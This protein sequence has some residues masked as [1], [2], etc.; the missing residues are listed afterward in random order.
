MAIIVILLLLVIQKVYF[1]RYDG[2]GDNKRIGPSGEDVGDVN[3]GGG[4]DYCV[5]GDEGGRYRIG[6]KGS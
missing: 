5:S 2:W 3:N 4:I 1:R 6:A